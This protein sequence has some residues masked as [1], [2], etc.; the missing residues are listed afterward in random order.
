[1][2]IYMVCWQQII[3]VCN[4]RPIE[5]ILKMSFFH[6]KE[7]LARLGGR[8]VSGLVAT[9]NGPGASW[10]TWGL[11]ESPER[12]QTVMWL[13]MLLCLVVI[14]DMSAEWGYFIKERL[15]IKHKWDFAIWVK[16]QNCT[17]LGRVTNGS[18]EEA[19]C[20]R[21]CWSI[22]THHVVECSC[23]S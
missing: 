9:D 17:Q 22:V 4:T 10:C 18:G 15:L 23:W 8:V 1:M 20:L 16:I 5:L 13:A 11:V 2:Y 7:L 3:K 14:K 21:A 6:H 19:Y 12:M